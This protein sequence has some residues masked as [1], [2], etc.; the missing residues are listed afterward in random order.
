[1]LTFELEEPILLTGIEIDTSRW[2]SSPGADFFATAR[3]RLP[4]A[5]DAKAPTAPTDPTAA[6]DPTDPTA[7]TAATAETAETAKT[8]A[9]AAGLA[10]AAGDVAGTSGFWRELAE[11][12]F[13]F[14]YDPSAQVVVGVA[15]AP[16]PCGAFQLVVD[17]PGSSNKN[18]SLHRVAAVG[19][20]TSPEAQAAYGRRIAEAAE[21]EARAAAGKAE[22][23]AKARAER[24]AKARARVVG[25]L[26]LKPLTAEVT[27]EFLVTDRTW[28]KLDLQL[29][30]QVL[31]TTNGAL[32][33]FLAVVV[34]VGVGGVMNMPHTMMHSFIESGYLSRR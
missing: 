12:E 23:K 29:L 9:T 2:S 17:V 3:V 24:E 28:R 14:T 4:V 26:T 8:A 30:E 21:A 33:Y 32:F 31:A 27:A 16:E 6:T 18:V 11:G 22:A 10:A 19:P 7:A 20:K 34:V 5:S 15:A 25:G 13:P 1:M